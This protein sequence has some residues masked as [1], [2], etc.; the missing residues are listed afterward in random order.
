MTFLMVSAS[1]PLSTF[2]E[3]I[4]KQ[5]KQD[6]S[7]VQLVTLLAGAHFTGSIAIFP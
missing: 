4:L 1:Y 3:P 7:F 2:L 6:W 5:F